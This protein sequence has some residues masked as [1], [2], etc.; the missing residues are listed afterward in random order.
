M[1]I[2]DGWRRRVTVLNATG[3]DGHR[4]YHKHYEN[5]TTNNT[6]VMPII[7]ALYIW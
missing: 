6:N 4:N 2:Q 5:I 3:A 1:L 7:L